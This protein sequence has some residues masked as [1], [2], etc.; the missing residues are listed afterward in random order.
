MPK[1]SL[2]VESWD[3]A[4]HDA[5]QRVVASGRFTMGPEVKAFEQQAAQYFGAPYCVMVNS[6]SSANLLGIAGAI[7]H[8]DIDLNPGDEVLV[9]AVSW[10]TT[11]YPLHQYGLKIRLVDI[12]PNTLNIDLSKLASA[13]TDK[14]KAIFAVNL[15]GNPNDFDQLSRVCEEHNL[16][17]FEDNCES[18]GATYKGRQAGSFGLF[19]TFSCFFSHQISTME[20]GLVLCHDE[21]M[22]HTL[23]SLRAHGWTREQPEH[24]HLNEEHDEFMSLFR[25]VLPGY[26]LRPLEMSGAIGQEQLKKLPA[27]VKQRQKNAEKFVSLF[28]QFPGLNIQREIGE[29]SWFG[30][31]LICES[32]L[33][34]R[35]NDI[36]AALNNADIEYRPIVAGNIYN[37]SVCQFMDIEPATDLLNADL[38]DRDGFFVGNSHENLESHLD[39]LHQTLQPFQD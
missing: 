21:K 10:S 31:S 14:T 29:S 5:I 19:G 11:Y 27:M 38:I 9:P 39:H 15:L 2:A 1:Y 22:Y 25:F 30:F 20:G 18:M 8:P 33:A 13:I 35:R 23:L 4:E 7:Y 17:F 3:Q 37:N 12:D 26:N 16:I 32:H 24:S 28:S 36:I 6:G 34:G